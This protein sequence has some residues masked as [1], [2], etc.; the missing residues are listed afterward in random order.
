MG[1]QFYLVQVNKTSFFDTGE[2]LWNTLSSE[3]ET[4]E[5]LLGHSSE[6]P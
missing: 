6:L 5:I 3:H 4:K 2:D 1:L